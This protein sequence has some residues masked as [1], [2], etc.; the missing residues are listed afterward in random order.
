VLLPK[1]V[2]VLK[3]V[4]KDTEGDSDAASVPIVIYFSLYAYTS[5]GAQG[6]CLKQGEALKSVVCMIK[7][8]RVF[9]KPVKSR[10]LTRS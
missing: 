2:E 4:A 3:T 5:P 9:L 6:G 1:S 10:P 8:F 7:P